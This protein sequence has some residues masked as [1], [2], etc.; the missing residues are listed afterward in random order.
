MGSRK[1]CSLELGI[2][3]RGSSVG[4]CSQI[5]A[6][7]DVPAPVW[8]CHRKAEVSEGIF[9]AVRDPD[10]LHRRLLLGDRGCLFAKKTPASILGTEMCRGEVVSCSSV[11]RKQEKNC[12]AGRLQ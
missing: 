7:A 12:G 5:S 1:C 2:K 9:R 4:S 8:W 11:L 3:V 10:T 6:G